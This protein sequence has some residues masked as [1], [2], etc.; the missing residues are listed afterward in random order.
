LGK[1]YFMADFRSALAFGSFFILL[2][3]HVKSEVPF[4]VNCQS[5]FE[6]TI[7]GILIAGYYGLLV[8]LLMLISY[9]LLVSDFWG[10]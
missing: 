4:L 2:L 8:S 5:V 7:S 10:D 1:R 3:I 9:A 6:C